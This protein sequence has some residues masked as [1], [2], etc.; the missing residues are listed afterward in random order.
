VG[1]TMPDF[2]LLKLVPEHSMGVSR[3]MGLDDVERVYG[4]TTLPSDPQAELLVAVGIPVAEAYRNINENL[5]RNLI[6]IGSLALLGIILAWIITEHYI[7]RPATLLTGASRR[8]MAGDLSARAQ[9]GRGY[10]ELYELAQ[11]FD[12]MVEALQKQESELRGLNQELEE[13]VASRTAELKR[14]HDMLQRFSNYLQN[15][16]EEERKKIS[17]EIHDELGQALTSIKMDLRQINK[18]VKPDQEAISQRIAISLQLIDQTIATMRRISSDLRPG[19]LDDLG[20]TAAVEWL[21][22]NFQNRTGIEVT[23]ECDPPDLEVPQELH[24]GLFR[25]IQEALTNVM[26]HAQATHV[27]IEINGSAESLKVEIRD[28]GQGFDP[29][30]L[31]QPRSLGLIGIRERAQLIGGEAKIIG[32]PGHGVQVNVCVPM[33]SVRGER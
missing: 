20:L 12:Q 13:R 21:V 28:N 2:G 1:K 29:K 33:A 16:L 5:L 7:L 4:F 27:W 9:L 22:T 11:V 3:S 26:R 30:I 8:M 14:S 31:G 15:M 23:F 18:Q 25:I 19:I 32:N 6:A 24:T 17:R 10:G